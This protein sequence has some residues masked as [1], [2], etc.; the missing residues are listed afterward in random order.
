MSGSSLNGWQCRRSG[1]GGRGVSGSASGVAVCTDLVWLP[2]GDRCHADEDVHLVWSLIILTMQIV[3]PHIET[4]GFGL[5][6][7]DRDE[8]HDVG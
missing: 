2:V 6:W 5:Y 4:E 8:E 3:L 1:D 7:K